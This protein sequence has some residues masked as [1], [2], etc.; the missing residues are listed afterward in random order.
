[1]TSTLLR[2]AIS[3][4]DYYKVVHEK[5]Q[6]NLI[7]KRAATLDTALAQRKLFR[8]LAISNKSLIVVGKN[9]NIIIT[10]TWYYH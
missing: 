7:L 2:A 10:A 4:R 5:T 8:Q 1:M 3:V 9:A 6:E